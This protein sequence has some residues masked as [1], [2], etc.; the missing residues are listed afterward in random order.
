MLIYKVRL[1]NLHHQDRNLI[2][3]AHF[4]FVSIFADLSSLGTQGYVNR[5]RGIRRARQHRVVD[6]AWLVAQ[7]LSYCGAPQ[8]PCT[9]D[10][11]RQ[12][13]S[14]GEQ[15]NDGV[16]V[17]LGSVGLGTRRWRQIFRGTITNQIQ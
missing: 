16:V 2:F 13:V 5:G 6:S 9:P 7:F 10:I 3:I 17:A 12:V 15:T 4:H 14:L 11:F 1:H 8:H